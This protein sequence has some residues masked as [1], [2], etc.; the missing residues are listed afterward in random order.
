MS[1]A[2]ISGGQLGGTCVNVGCVPSK[3]LIEAAKLYHASKSATFPGMT[4]NGVKLDFPSL[5]HG[6]RGFVA[7]MREE[8]YESVIEHY[9][10][11]E[12]VKGMATLS[13]NGKVTVR[14]GRETREIAAENILVATGSRPSVP[15]IPGLDKV[16]FYTTDDIWNLERLPSSLLLIGGGAVGLEIG[17]ALQRLGCQV[18]LVEVLDRVLPGA[19]P[20][21]S[22]KLAEILTGEGMRIIT[23]GRVTR[24]DGHGDHKHA[25]VITNAGPEA[26][27]FEELLIGTGR[28]PNVDGLSL[29]EVGIQTDE[30]GF[31]KVDEYM[32]TTNPRIYAAGDCVSKPY[33]LE[34]LSAKEGAVAASNIIESRSVR[35]DYTAVPVV[36]FTEPQAAF[37]GM[38]ERQAVERYGACSCRVVDMQSVAKA[39][40]TGGMGIAKIVINPQTE[41]V[42]GVHALAPNAAEF[43]TEAALY[44]KHNHKVTDIIDTLHV[45]PTLGEAIKLAAQ[46]FIRPLEKMSC[47]VE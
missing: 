38:T 25:E 23:R 47:C 34:T 42:V 8:K 32:Q 46:A 41:A 17:Q 44:V 43:I 33:M 37:V 7:R 5:I 12:V 2:I 31:I 10:N 21:V 24:V 19:E 45:F 9:E 28:I 35:M 20:E 14:S 6:L 22:K 36:V 29:A 11:V 39:R 1:V 13:P 3:Y 15:R 4:P 30:R 16:K 18:T 40:M 26:L 27:E